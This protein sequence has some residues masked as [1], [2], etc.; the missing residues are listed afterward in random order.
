MKRIE[1]FDDRLELG[2]ATALSDCYGRLNAEYPTW[3]NCCIASPLCKSA[4][5]HDRGNIGNACAHW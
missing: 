3:R 2:A 1:D 5:R 4:T